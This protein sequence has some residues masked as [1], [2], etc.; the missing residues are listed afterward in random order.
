M[1]NWKLQMWKSW[2][3]PK[4]S[5]I[6][7]TLLWKADSPRY[8]SMPT[9][10]TGTVFRCSWNSHILWYLVAECRP[11]LKSNQHHVPYVLISCWYWNGPTSWVNILTGPSGPSNMDNGRTLDRHS[12]LAVPGFA[13]LQEADRTGPWAKHSSKFYSWRGKPQLMLKD[14]QGV[15]ETLAMFIDTIWHQNLSQCSCGEFHIWGILKN[16]L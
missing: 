9:A 1:Q 2:T 13:D 15:M 11:Q 12:Q 7:Q 4:R 10:H 3:S 8:C 16:S 14:A 6:S 5:K